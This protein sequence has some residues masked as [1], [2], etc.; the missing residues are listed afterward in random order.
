MV[1]RR[2]TP[3]ASSK[4]IAARRRL[5]QRLGSSAAWSQYAAALSSALGAR[6]EEEADAAVLDLRRVVAQCGDDCQALHDDY[7][8]AVATE[9][10]AAHADAATA[11]LPAAAAS[12]PAGTWVRGISLRVAGR[13]RG[14]PPE[15]A[16]D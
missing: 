10:V 11:L 7:L 6:S 3:P 1:A 15:C 9:A 14:V 4:R 2:D 13:Q 5:Q 12:M 16:A 8:A